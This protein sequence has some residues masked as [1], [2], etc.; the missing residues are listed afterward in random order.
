M[1]RMSVVWEREQDR[2]A[3][4]RASAIVAPP[5]KIRSRAASLL[6]SAIVHLINGSRGNALNLDNS[7]LLL[8]LLPVRQ[9]NRCPLPVQESCSFMVGEAGNEAV[10]RLE[11]DT[12]AAV[13]CI[14]QRMADYMVITRFALML[15]W[16]TMKQQC[17]TRNNQFRHKTEH[18][19][20]Q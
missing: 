20:E 19:L 6:G 3:D 2:I 15:L 16:S 14:W 8:M 7:T 13:S 11:L 9:L 1:N 5:T 18:H 17:R 12:H 10:I 4:S